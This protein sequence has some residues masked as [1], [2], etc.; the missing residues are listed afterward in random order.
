MRPPLQPEEQARVLAA[1]PAIVTL[2]EAI[3]DQ[4][5]LRVVRAILETGSED[6]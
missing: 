5:R 2:P 6:Q 3:S 1:G 4:E